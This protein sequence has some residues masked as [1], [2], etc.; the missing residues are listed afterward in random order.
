MLGRVGDYV[1]NLEDTTAWEFGVWV[2]RVAWTGW[3]GI[4]RPR[5]SLEGHWTDAAG[6]LCDFRGLA[7]H[8]RVHGDGNDEWKKK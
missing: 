7:V 3:R 6:V 2:G 1:A 4:L 5:T 8:A